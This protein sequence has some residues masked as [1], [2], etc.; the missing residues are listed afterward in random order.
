MKNQFRGK[1][2]QE[3]W[4]WRADTFIAE[5]HF[6]A[7]RK[8]LKVFIYFQH[9]LEI[10][11]FNLD[12][13]YY[14]SHHS[15]G[16]QR[17]VAHILVLKRSIRQFHL[18]CSPATAR[19]HI[20]ASQGAVGAEAGEQVI[21]RQ[22]HGQTWFSWAWSLVPPENQSCSSHFI[23]PVSGE[24]EKGR[25]LGREGATADS[26]L[27]PHHKGICLSFPSLGSKNISKLH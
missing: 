25:A 16:E 13:S 14:F 11:I 19:P 8:L 18:H 17:K 5:Y 27:V 12:P 22:Q 6:S 2:D 1:T 3:P 23:R 7:D 4:L 21:T 26:R 24:E 15:S 10:N 20:T 9:L